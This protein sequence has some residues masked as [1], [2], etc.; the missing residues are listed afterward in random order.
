MIYLDNNA[1]TRPLAGVVEAA[2][3]VER[4]VWGN[5]SSVHR[6]GQAARREVEL[7]RAA[8]AGLIGARPRN[9]LLTGGGTEANNLALRGGLAGALSGAGAGASAGDGGGGGCGVVVTS[10][11]EHAAVREVAE[12]L[13]KRGVAG[14]GVGVNVNVG[15]GVGGG[16]GAG[17]VWLPVDEAGRVEVGALE[18]VLAGLASQ[19]IG[20]AVVSVMGANNETGVMQPLAAVCGAVEAYR[21]GTGQDGGGGGS[22]CGVKVVLHCDATQ[23]VGKVLVDVASAELRGLDLLTLSA[24]KFHG[25]KGVG[26]LWV[27]RGVR[28]A[29]QQVGGPQERDR[30]GGTESVAA[31]AGMGVAAE[32]AGAWLGGGVGGEGDGEMRG[33]V[34][35]GARLRDRLEVG[36]VAA[37]GEAGVEAVVNGAGAARLWN[38]T[39]IGFSRLGAEAVLM[40]LSERGVCVSAGAACSSGSLEASLVL[41]AMGVSEVVA[42]GSVRFS[43]SRFTTEAEVDEAV[44]VVRAVVGRLARTLPV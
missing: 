29:A 3:R 35:E 25:P 6:F 18:E 23:L 1:T 27:R 14:G 17:V 36:V 20:V 21:N 2:A 31:I 26:G 42:H 22:G 19:G 37:A 5:A 9:V 38:T 24:H 28:L 13:A 12:D 40:G 15:V 33:G 7:A 4:E 34:V 44:G 16:V 10:R 43:L 32:A 30:R 39:N 11:V 8:V 41:K